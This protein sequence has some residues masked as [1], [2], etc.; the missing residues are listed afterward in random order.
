MKQKR[1]KMNALLALPLEEQMIAGY[2]E[3]FCPKRQSSRF[4]ARQWANN[5]ESIQAISS[6]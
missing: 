4:R 2:S 6:Y 5:D 1:N 3:H